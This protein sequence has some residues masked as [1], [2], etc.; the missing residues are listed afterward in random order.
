MACQFLLVATIL[1][2]C[3]EGF[4]VLQKAREEEYARQALLMTP[5]P[6]GSFRGSV[7]FPGDDVSI[8]SGH[9]GRRRFSFVRRDGRRTSLSLPPSPLLDRSPTYRTRRSPRMDPR[10][11]LVHPR[12]LGYDFPYVDD[13]G[14]VTPSSQEDV[15]SFSAHAP[16]AQHRRRLSSGTSHCSKASAVSTL[17]SRRTRFGTKA[18]ELLSRRRTGGHEPTVFPFAPTSRGVPDVIVDRSRNDSVSVTSPQCNLDA[19]HLAVF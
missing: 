2:R 19:Q 3:S 16:V 1:F 9:S 10:V 13:S 14:A 8:L 6:S 17:E 11:P 4:V 7:L 18:E 15:F 12:P 5:S